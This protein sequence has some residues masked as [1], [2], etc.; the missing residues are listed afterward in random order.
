M[1]ND[2]YHEGLYSAYS[3]IFV[4]FIFISN[5]VSFFPFICSSSFLYIAN[6]LYSNTE[7]AQSFE[8]AYF[9]M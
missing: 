8:N 5:S 1:L 2:L 4:M 9:C 7:L 3:A 6:F